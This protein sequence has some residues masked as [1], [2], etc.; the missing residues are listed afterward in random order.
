MEA[1]PTNIIFLLS[2]DYKTAMERFKIEYFERDT[3]TKFPLVVSIQT[4]ELNIIQFKLKQIFG[5]C[6]RSELLEL[7]KAMRSN[8]TMLNGNAAEEKFSLLELFSSQGIISHDFVYVNWHRFDVVDKMKCFE[9]CQYF[10]DIWYPGT[11]DIDIF[12]DSFQWIV[13]VSDNGTIYR[14]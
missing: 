12:D 10:D 6:E 7:L 2:A 5:L 8:Q 14:W 13:S 9:L 3:E 11:D 4:A 1:N